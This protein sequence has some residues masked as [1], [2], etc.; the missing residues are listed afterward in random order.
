MKR[1]AAT[2]LLFGLLISGL[3]ACASMSS[4]NG[5][6]T[7]VMGTYEGQG[8]EILLADN[9]IIVDGQSAATDDAQAVYIA[10]DIVYYE[11]GHDFTYGEGTQSDAHSAEE[12]QSHT[13]V[14][15][16]AP[17][18]YVISG[19]L[20]RGQIAVDLGEEAVNDP[21]AVVT[22]VLNGAD[23]TCEVAPAVIFYNVYECG[24][25]NTETA[26]KNVDTAA[27][28]ANILLADGSINTV[29]G[30]YVARIYKPE[31]VVLNED[32]TEVVDAKKL[33]KYDGAVYSK[34]SMNIDGGE[35]GSGLLR[36]FASNEGM[37]SEL[38]LTINGG[39][40]HI[41][42]GNDG[43]NTNEDY[44][45]VT[46]VNGGTVDI[47]VDGSTGEG[48]GIDSNGWLIINGGSV[49]AQA[50]SDSGDA[51]IDS[52][53]GIH[54]NGGTVVATG[55]MLDHIEESDRNFAVFRFAASQ[56]GG[57]YAIKNTADETVAEREVENR[58]SYLLI[59]HE[60]LS[61][62]EYS[63]WSDEEKLQVSRSGGDAVM[64]GGMGGMERP[65]EERGH[66]MTPPD[67][68]ERPEPSGDM[69]QP[70]DMPGGMRPEEGAAH[71]PPS[72]SMMPEDAADT[73]AIQKG[74]NYYSVMDAA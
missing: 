20:S 19:T 34:M 9:G 45:S 43:I 25:K 70:E 16:T 66:G 74:E 47:R 64:P 5:E 42:S 48:D 59:S 55:N 33:H 36:I 12:A 6:K 21:S 22:L 71:F 23:I 56:K 54:I 44:V 73:F 69:M 7:P 62:G 4:D 46:T 31:S 26:Q 51:G 60:D 32:G 38:H 50:C 39:N 3:S 29:Y 18:T 53:M 14:H 30:S 27:A 63:L 68:M 41:V 58:F 15:I 61:E 37:D 35:Q 65:G 11:A 1:Y 24:T 57:R 72:V 49:F 52:D 10:N 2:I 13:V 17:G 40:I 28:G 67:Q 8:V